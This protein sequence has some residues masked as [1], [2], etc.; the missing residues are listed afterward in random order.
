MVS[1]EGES[2]SDIP[3]HFAFSDQ[4]HNPE[5]LKP[6]DIL[7][8]NLSGIWRA[9]RLNRW[10]MVVHDTKHSSEGW[11]SNEDPE[12]YARAVATTFGLTANEAAVTA[13]GRTWVLQKPVQ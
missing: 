3:Q 10:L 1:L 8:R 11:A 13:Q 9:Q 12:D 7:H 4:I 2:M 6:G 5:V